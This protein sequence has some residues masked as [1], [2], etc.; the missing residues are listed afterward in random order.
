MSYSI[1]SENGIEKEELIKTVDSVDSASKTSP[2]E[3]E[4]LSNQKITT[5]ESSESDQEVPMTAP[6]IYQAQK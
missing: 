5:S 2:T 3:E 1:R 6:L 4:H